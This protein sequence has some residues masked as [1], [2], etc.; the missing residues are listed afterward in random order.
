[1]RH[2]PIAARVALAL[3]DLQR[4]LPLPAAV[5]VETS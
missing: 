5:F 2:S 4:R 3:L 1:M